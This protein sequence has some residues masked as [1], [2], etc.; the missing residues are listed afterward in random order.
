MNTDEN[1]SGPAS[2]FQQV[3]DNPRDDTEKP[4]TVT[5]NAKRN[6]QKVI[7]NKSSFA[8]I[9]KKTDIPKILTSSFKSARI[10][11]R[12][13]PSQNASDALDNNAP[14]T[15]LFQT[16]DTSVDNDIAWNTEESYSDD[17]EGNKSPAWVLTDILHSFGE[18][19]RPTGYLV[20]RANELVGLLETHESL[21]RDLVLQSILHKIQNLLLHSNSSVI[22]CG[23]RVIWCIIDDYKS[24]ALF[25]QFNLHYFLIHSLAKD[26]KPN[27][28]EREESLKLVRKFVDVEDGVTLLNLDIMKALVAVADNS[29]DPLRTS[30][31]ETICEVSVLAPEITFKANGIKSMLQCVLDG[32]SSMTGTCILTIIKLLDSPDARRYV[33]DEKVI[34]ALIC[35]F[36]DIV[37]VRIERLQ[38]L[39]YVI[40]SLLKS[41]PGLIAFSQNDFMPLRQLIS[42]LTFDSSPVRVVLIHIFYEIFHIKSLPW[43]VLRDNTQETATRGSSAVLF[44]RDAAVKI[45]QP[46]SVQA[47]RIPEREAPFINHYTSLLLQICFKCGLWD[48]LTRIFEDSTDKKFTK[49]VVFLLSEMSYLQTFLVPK[50]LH[51]PLA[52]SFRL[53]RLLEKAIRKH[54][55][56]GLLPSELRQEALEQEKS[57][58]VPSSASKVLDAIDE[59]NDDSTSGLTTLIT[60]GSVQLRLQNMSSGIDIKALVFKTGVL[61]TKAFAKWDWPLIIQLMRAPLRNRKMF[62]EVVRTTKFYKR[63]LSFYRPFK[64]RF[65]MLRKTPGN[66][67]YVRAGC[68]I[69]KNLLSHKNGVNYLSENKLLPQIAECLAQVDPYSGITAA[70]A[71]FSKGKLENTI[72]SAF[73]K[74]VEIL[75]G[76]LNGIRMMEQWW[77]FDMLYHITDRASNREDLTKL[78]IRNLKYNI[79]GHCRIILKKVAST[80]NT[81]CRLLA[82]R[83]LGDLLHEGGVYESYACH[84]LVDQFCDRSLQVSDVAVEALTNYATDSST[85]DRLIACQPSLDHLGNK[86]AK[87]IQAIFS[88]SSGFD[89]L[90]NQL[91]FVETEMEAWVDTKN[92]VYVREIEAFIAK[93]LFNFRNTSTL[94]MPYHFFGA[95]VKTVE[96]VRLLES[97]ET[98]SS[99]SNTIRNY[100]FMIRNSKEVQFYGENL[101]DTVENTILELKSVL[102]A[103]GN[104]SVSEYG[105]NL[106]EM[107][108]LVEDIH[109]ITENSVNLSL[110]GSCFFIMGLVAQTDQGSEILDDL[111]WYATRSSLGVN[112]PICLPRDFAG[113]LEMEK[114]ELVTKVPIESSVEIFDKI[115]E[116]DFVPYNSDERVME[117]T[118]SS[119][120]ISGVPGS[121]TYVTTQYSREYLMMY[122][123]YENLN[124]ILVNQAKAYGNLA[125]LKKRYP[126]IFSTEPTVLKFIMRVLNLYRVK[127]AVRKHLLT[128]LINFNKMMEI[129]LRRERRKMKETIGG[130][131]PQLPTSNLTI[132]PLPLPLARSSPSLSPT[133]TWTKLSRRTT[134]DDDGGVEPVTLTTISHSNNKN[135]HQTPFPSQSQT[136][137]R[138]STQDHTTIGN[139]VLFTSIYKN[140]R[141][142]EATISDEDSEG[143]KETE[144]D[145]DREN[146]SDK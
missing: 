72:S 23:F 6:E 144:E 126:S 132:P 94:E 55:K 104:I 117:H 2:N 127:G 66:Q 24:L 18:K 75:S 92:K 19:D 83:I 113:F 96:G 124:L 61:T 27:D 9:K 41:W 43:I 105:I 40:A 88:T 47:T 112:L 141:R 81:S 100:V 25:T 80:G 128:E 140:S 59:L 120:T 51:T 93:R 53:N 11:S 82:T 135:K 10:R 35:P 28:I 46:K 119:N 7:A 54:H 67:I 44:I 20:R 36:M 14:H 69:F 58:I 125:K 123:V 145:Q 146:D 32:V 102:W 26:G 86:S 101:V 76:D 1:P 115:M 4:K 49:K 129:L 45:H 143:K 57:E 108:G 122:K 22:A 29:D 121:S 87:L 97:T 110:K 138:S 34:Q 30:A 3:L 60:Q 116:E 62:D 78:I 37:H 142:G 39:A 95:L 15:R 77:L 118:N 139:S 73:F 89:Y 106:L 136:R 74:F 71:L 38:A 111:G 133:P 65:S 90:Q 12:T 48:R 31:L 134:L 17:S 68:E 33:M 103:I 114:N 84:A 56:T 13:L 8:Q 21:R 98:F 5:K 42:C 85:V 130:S 50:K 64:Y 107:S 79:P 63:L 91:N 109:C 99:F 16:V 70:D 52:P 137:S 131:S